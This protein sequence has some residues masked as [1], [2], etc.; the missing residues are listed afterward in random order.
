MDDIR[1][2][3]VIKVLHKVVQNGCFRGTTSQQTSD[4]PQV[5]EEVSVGPYTLLDHCVQDI[6]PRMWSG[7]DLDPSDPYIDL[8]DLVTNDV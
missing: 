2:Y 1:G 3:L 7:P 8:S 5:L 6:T 4:P